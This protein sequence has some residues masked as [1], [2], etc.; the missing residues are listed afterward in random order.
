MTTENIN[1][2]CPFCH[3]R[4]LFRFPQDWPTLEEMEIIYAHAALHAS[5][6]K[7][8]RTM[9]ALNIG[10]R[11]LKNR[12]EQPLPVRAPR[13]MNR[14]EIM[15]ATDA[16]HCGLHLK[17]I[18]PA[19]ACSGT[20]A[21]VGK[22]EDAQI[23]DIRFNEAVYGMSNREDVSPGDRPHLTFVEADGQERMF[24]FGDECPDDMTVFIIPVRSQ[25]CMAVVVKT[26]FEE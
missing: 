20:Y 18:G 11:A 5:G 19:G 12:T 4:V 2:F 17:P 1:S 3:S 10:F 21:L 22:N 15:Q 25:H 8:R 24:H 16:L 26:E 13:P 6:N 9:Q 23:Y 7:V 14:E